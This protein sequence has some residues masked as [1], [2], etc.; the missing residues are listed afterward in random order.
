[1]R[2][3][4]GCG[5]WAGSSPLP[6]ER[7]PSTAS[8]PTPSWLEQGLVTH[9]HVRAMCWG[10]VLCA[11][12][13]PLCQPA[14]GG[15]HSI[16]PEASVA[17]RGR[18]LYTGHR[19]AWV[20][21]DSKVTPQVTRPLTAEVFL[22]NPGLLGPAWTAVTCGEGVLRGLG[23]GG[24]LCPHQSPAVYLFL[25]GGRVLRPPP[26]W[27]FPERTAGSSGPLCCPEAMG[28]SSTWPPACATLRRRSRCSCCSHMAP[29]AL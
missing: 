26:R 27:A 9:V 11:P 15:Q 28:T 18:Q 20:W 6:W 10:P 16:C 23:A 29:P 4:C 12:D 13:G 3:P 25:F 1:M 5:S 24:Q 8:P 17:G 21:L 7:K 19:E 22:C 14:S 2:R